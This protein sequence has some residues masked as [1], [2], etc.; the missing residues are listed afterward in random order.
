MQVQ[1]ET[2]LNLTVEAPYIT[3]EGNYFEK[4]EDSVWEKENVMCL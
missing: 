1:L 4:P 3:I 2:W